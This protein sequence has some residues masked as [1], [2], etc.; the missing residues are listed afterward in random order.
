MG[1][2]RKIKNN[3]KNLPKVGENQIAET[4]YERKVWN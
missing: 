2:K 3:G 4:K 1:E